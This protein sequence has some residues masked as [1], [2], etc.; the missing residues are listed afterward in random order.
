VAYLVRQTATPKPL[1]LQKD[2]DYIRLIF[3]SL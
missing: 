2:L 1:A 3:L